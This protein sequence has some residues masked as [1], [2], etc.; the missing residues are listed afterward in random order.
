MG[1]SFKKLKNHYVIHKKSK[2]INT[3]DPIYFKQDT[4]SNLSISYDQEFRTYRQ[5]HHFLLSR[6]KI[7]AQTLFE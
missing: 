6:P 7:L 3:R 5:T 1:L 2:K 4:F